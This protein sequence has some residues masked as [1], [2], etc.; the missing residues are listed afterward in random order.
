MMTGAVVAAV[1]T[2]PVVA[3]TVVTPVAAMATMM[4]RD[5]NYV[6]RLHL[7]VVMAARG[8]LS[9]HVTRAGVGI[10]DG[11]TEVRRVVGGHCQVQVVPVMVIGEVSS[12][13]YSKPGGCR[14]PL[15][16]VLIRS[17]TRS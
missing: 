14:L 5:I 15:I 6:G 17:V 10:N 3:V 12:S 13:I 11:L 16:A 2:R 4:I 9:W 7:S 1:T 8:V